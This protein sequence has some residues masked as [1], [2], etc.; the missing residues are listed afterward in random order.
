MTLYQACT[1]DVVVVG[2]G[3][4][5][6]RTALAL[7][8][9]SVLLIQ[10]SAFGHG[11]ASP[12]ARGGIAAALGR[13]DSPSQH[14]L[15]TLRV[16]GGLN[17]HGVVQ[18]LTGSAEGEV[19]RLCALGAR[20]DRDSQGH[21]A[22]GR[23]AG[24]SRHR[25]VHAGGDRTGSEIVRA[26]AVAVRAAT[27]VSVLDR[28]FVRDLVVADDRVTG[29]EVDRGEELPRLRI[30]AEA[31]VLASGGLGQL[32]ERTTNPSENTG[33]GLAIAHRAGAL[34]TDLEFVQFHPTA[35][36]VATDPLPLLTE[37]L[38]GAGA[39]IVDETGHRFLVDHHPDAELAPRDVLARVLFRH[40]ERGHQAF[41][42]VHEQPGNELTTR[43]PAA[44][45]AARSAGF[46]PFNEPLPIT[47]A[48]HYSMGGIQTDAR[49]RTTIPGLWACGET[50][51]TGAHGANRLASNS[52]LEGLVFGARIAADLRSSVHGRFRSRNP[53]RTGHWRPQPDKNLR[54]A[55]R[56]LMWRHAGLERNEQGLLRAR[57]LIRD[58]R[59]EDRGLDPELTNL[60]TVAEQLVDAA[61]RRRQSCGSHFRTDTELTAT[62]IEHAA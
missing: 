62:K 13:H 33:D 6:L 25:I 41:L 32:Y 14:A 12:L 7:A 34:L 35:L 40:L 43:F 22:L 2:G 27:H 48:A 19:E 46:D 15:D 38:R 3:V 53:N 44:V 5:G 10:K 42:E 51:A 17:D 60:L 37:A 9:R 24:H 39:R 61:Q 1:T 29:V 56:K 23:E 59:D 54:A 50:A 47:P 8:P 30:S 58:W 49:G 57:D 4:A 21:L 31:V 11:G 18:L 20:F 45:Q 55:L 26:L 36:R 16:G 52:L 28:S